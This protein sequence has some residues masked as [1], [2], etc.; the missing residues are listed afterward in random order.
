MYAED[1]DFSVKNFLETCSMQ[2]W[3]SPGQIRPFKL[4]LYSSTIK[5]GKHI[6]T[7]TEKEKGEMSSILN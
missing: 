7:E 4:V 1:K 5:S 2:R 6:F 3:I